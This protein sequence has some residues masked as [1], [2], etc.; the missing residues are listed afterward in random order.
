L[1][2]QAQKKK[3][4]KTDHPSGRRDKSVQE[5]KPFLFAKIS[6]TKSHVPAMM[7][8]EYLPSLSKVRAGGLFSQDYTEKMTPYSADI[9]LRSFPLASFGT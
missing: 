8:A 6:T 1:R 7:Q 2:R 5:L 3:T 9:Q 4:Q